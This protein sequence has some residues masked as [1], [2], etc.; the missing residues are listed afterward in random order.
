MGLTQGYH[1]MHAFLSITISHHTNARKIILHNDRFDLPFSI[2]GDEHDCRASKHGHIPAIY[3][4]AEDYFPGA[5][6]FN[7]VMA[8]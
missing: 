5:A 3:P 4:K 6:E 1:T 2:K 8:S 7:K